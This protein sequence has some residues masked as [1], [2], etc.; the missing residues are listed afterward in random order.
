M[1]KNNKKFHKMNED[2]NLINKFALFNLNQN[3]PYEFGLNGGNDNFNENLNINQIIENKNHLNQNRA[4]N[5]K[6]SIIH[7]PNRIKYFNT[8]N[9]EQDFLNEN[10]I[11]HYYYNLNKPN[12]PFENIQHNNN[13]NQ[14]IFNN[15]NSR[16]NDINIR[17]N[18]F[19][20]R[21]TFKNKC[22]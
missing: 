7:I 19:F 12:L 4:N 14:N 1:K 11:Q 6:N 8:V 3:Q 2:S 9:N 15:K 5:F 22:K 18:N 10:K 20:Y 16:N 17:R 13:I 21:K